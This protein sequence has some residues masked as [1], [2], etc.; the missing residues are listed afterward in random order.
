MIRFI[1]TFLLAT[2]FAC[3]AYA[4]FQE[5]NMSQGGFSGPSAVME[6]KTAS[7]A[8]EAPEDTTCVL[9]GNIVK[10]LSR[11]RYVFKDATGTVNVD[12]PPHVF[13]TLTV[14]PST[15][16]RLTGE[17]GGKRRRDNQDPHV[18]IRYLEI[19]RS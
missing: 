19:L 14:T 1:S 4:E 16:V 3:S 5:S 11:N 15:K 2:V 9:Q 10:R 6:V 7:A 8:A 17:V 18:R 12:I 13:G